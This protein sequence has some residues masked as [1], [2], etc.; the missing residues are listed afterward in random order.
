MEIFKHLEKSNCRECGEKTC[1]AFAAA[2]YQSRKDIDMCP[3][4]D[5][6]I[7]EYY[8]SPDDKPEA[9]EEAGEAF[10][11][12]LLKALLEMDLAEAALRTGGRY[13]GRKLI[14]KILGKD[15]GVDSKGNFSSD[16]HINPWVL[17]PFLDYVVHSS[18]AEPSGE[19]VSFRELKEGRDFSYPF[20]KKR[21]ELPMKQIADNYTD[22]FDDLVH[23]FGGEKVEEQFES[24]VSVVLHP[25]PKVPM[26]ICYLKPEDGLDSTLNIYFDK[27]SD[28][29]LKNGT[30]FTICAGLANMFEKL[31]LR[32]SAF[33]A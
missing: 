26:M 22:L 18:G 25:L 13:T 33:T 28:H 2:V 1:L 10:T 12:G 15:F 9:A 21:C 3:K 8:A 23:L 31:S 24:D 6:K 30:L 19:L 27:A 5:S 20:F 7:I 16:I 14:L 32:H 11:Q 29:N 17:G 4:L